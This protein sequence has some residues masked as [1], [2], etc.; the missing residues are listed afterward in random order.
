[1]LR[2]DGYVKVL[3]FGWR[4]VCLRYCGATQA[5]GG[6][7]PGIMLG[8]VAYMSPE[9]ARGAQI[10]SGSDAFRLALCCISF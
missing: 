10:E 4:G 5:S 6:H 1:M 9:Q 7:Q 8:P 3:D 2:S